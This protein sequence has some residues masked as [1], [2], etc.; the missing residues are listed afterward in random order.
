MVTLRA[1]IFYLDVLFKGFYQ[2][3]GCKVKGLES[4]PQMLA[5]L[6]LASFF[7]LVIME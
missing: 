6:A 3:R 5:K 1:T 2:P 4:Y 7:V